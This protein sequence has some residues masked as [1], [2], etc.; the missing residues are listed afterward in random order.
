MNIDDL[1]LDAYEGHVRFGGIRSLQRYA[2]SPKLPASSRVMRHFMRH[3][4]QLENAKKSGIGDRE[5]ARRR[6]G[7]GA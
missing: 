1:L 7:Q 5:C 3:Q 6:R 4:R 2:M